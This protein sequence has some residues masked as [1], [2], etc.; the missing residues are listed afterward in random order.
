MV[1]PQLGNSPADGL[2]IAEIAKAKPVQTHPHPSSCL[3][4][5]QG[6][7]PSP[8]GILALRCEVFQELLGT[9]FRCR[10]VA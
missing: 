1:D 6:V 10:I 5:A 7:E 8:E 4:V 2:R 9:I 3:D